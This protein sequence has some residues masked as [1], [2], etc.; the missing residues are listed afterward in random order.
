M[1]DESYAFYVQSLIRIDIPCSIF[2]V[3]DWVCSFFYRKIV[4]K[5]QEEIFEKF[6]SQKRLFMVMKN[7]GFVCYFFLKENST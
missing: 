3:D 2:R 7:V 5:D 4:T 1:R 6:S